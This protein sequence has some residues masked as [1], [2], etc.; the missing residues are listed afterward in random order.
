MIGRVGD[1]G[2]PFGMRARMRTHPHDKFWRRKHV[3]SVLRGYCI[4]QGSHHSNRGIG[5]DFAA[6][7]FFE[8]MREL[9]CKKH[10][11]P[12]LSCITED[13]RRVLV[14]VGFCFVDNKQGEMAL[15]LWP[16]AR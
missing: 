4:L 5:V 3:A 12:K 11:E 7:S 1:V 6:H 10:P 13:Q 14:H 15:V 2:G 9:A 16:P 8:L